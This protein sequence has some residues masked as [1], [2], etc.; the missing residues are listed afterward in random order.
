MFSVIFLPSVPLDILTRGPLALKA[1]KEALARG[2]T[3]VRRVPLMLIGQGGAGKTSTKKSLKGICFDPEEDSTVGI[4]VDPSYFKVST[5]TWRTGEQGQDQ[6]SDT[7]VYLDYHLARCIADSLKTQENSTQRN[8]DTNFLDPETIEVPGQPI[9][10]QESREGEDIKTPS[11]VQ[12]EEAAVAERFPRGDLN[13]N[14]KKLIQESHR[15]SLSTVP[16]EVAAVAEQF[17]RG[18]VDDSTEDIY[19][20]FWDFAGQSVYYVTHPLFLATRAMFLLVYDLSLN[21][22]DEAKP[23]LKQGVFEESEESYDLKTNFDYL[24]FW[25]KSVASLARGQAEGSRLEETPSVKLPPVFLV[26]THADKPYGRGDPR[27][28]ARKIFGCL[29]RKPYGAHL[30]DVFWIDNTSLSVNNSDCP[31]VVRL[32]QEI[33]AV[34]KELPFINETIPINWLKFEKALQAKKEV[35]NKRISLES[36]KDIAKNDCNI[37]DEKEFETL[38]NYLHDIRSLIHYEDTVRLNTLVVLDPQWLVDVF[39]KVITVKPYD[40]QE[41]EFL[42]LW[43]KLESTGVLDENLV[44]HVWGPLFEDKETLESLIGIMERFSLLCPWSVHASSN[45][46]YLVPSMLMSCPTTELLE[47]V[48]SAN[49]PSL[50]VKFSNG[51]VPPAFFSR[52]VVQFIQWGRERFWSE[53]TP[54]LFIGFARFYTS[55]EKC[56]VI[57]ICHSSSVEVVVQGE[58]SA[59]FLPSS[60]EE[61]CARRVCRQL[62]LILECMRNQFPWLENMTYEMCV[63]CPVCSKEREVAFCQTHGEKICKQEQCLHF[64]TVSELCSDTRNI[65]CRRSAVAQDTTVEIRQFSPWFPAPKE[66]VTELYLYW[67]ILWSREISLIADSLSIPARPVP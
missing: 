23:V 47:L 49:I 60:G 11:T 40:P 52:L 26:C 43:R 66:Q 63:I 17:L 41:K 16:E 32:R 30:C 28:L 3:S 19:F 31:E 4:D 58:N 51:E 20:T 5:E 53:E 61:T 14:G 34:A 33:I 59:P 25:M 36:A 67:G 56:S 1:Y 10:T 18:D 64:W 27:K 35:G 54:Q 38:M 22:D 15:L 45:R 6:N 37:V 50:F 12:K 2:E 29:K 65:Y 24:D 7:A 8:T 42:H 55:E 62:S 39:K 46:Q 9:T 13:D 21:P 57:F 48:E 44:A